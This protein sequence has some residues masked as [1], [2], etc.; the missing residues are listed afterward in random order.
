[1]ISRALALNGAK[2]YITGRTAEKLERVVETF[3]KGI[4]GKLIP[5]TCDITSKES[6]AALYDNIASREHCV[7]ILVNNA[8]ISTGRI[9]MAGGS[10][11]ADQ[12]K[13]QLFITEESK[14]ESWVDDYRTNTGA[15]YFTTAAFLPLLQ[16][17]TEK[18][19]GWSGT[20]INIASISGQVKT[21]QKH[22]SYNAAK[23]ATIHL[24]RMLAAEI[25]GAGLKIRVNSISPGVFPSE[26]TAK[27]QSGEDQ[28]SELP[29]ERGQGFPSGRPGKEEEMASTVLFCAANQYLNGQDIVVDGGATLS[30]GR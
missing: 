4:P 30:M 8:G 21:A 24:S 2:V 20:V 5:V 1:M 14:F 12:L 16:R 29:A 18:F 23:A 7:C 11:N 6:I 26:M 3:G 15:V 22:F 9:P 27:G 28:R 10:Q 19:K 13:D 17:S 25:A